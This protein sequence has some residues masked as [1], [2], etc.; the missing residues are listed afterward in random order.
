MPWGWTWSPRA[1]RTCWIT[2]RMTS[3][4]W[5]SLAYQVR[6]AFATT[7]RSWTTSLESPNLLVR[8][9]FLVTPFTFCKTDYIF[10]IMAYWKKKKTSY[11]KQSFH[12][13]VHIVRP[14]FQH[15]LTRISWRTTE[16]SGWAYR[17]HMVN[18]GMF[19]QNIPFIKSNNHSGQKK[20]S[21]YHWSNLAYHK[22]FNYIRYL[23]WCIRKV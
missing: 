2:S 9:K 3:L 15:G 12:L 10:L 11:N 14:R 18:I 5:M 6:F 13:K 20:K 8:M 21:D 23:P 7:C 22:M 19:N 1:C 17:Q 16:L 4:T